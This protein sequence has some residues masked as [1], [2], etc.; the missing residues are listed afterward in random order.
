MIYDDKENISKLRMNR[1]MVDIESKKYVKKQ[2]KTTQIVFR[3]FIFSSVIWAVGT[4]H[5]F[6]TRTVL[7]TVEVPLINT[8]V[9]NTYTGF[10]IREETVYTSNFHNMNFLV[11]ENTRIRRNTAVAANLQQ[12]MIAETGGIVSFNLDG[13]E[14]L[15]ISDLE[16][17]MN[18]GNLSL[19]NNTDAIFRI[20][21]SNNWNIIS[22]IPIKYSESISSSNSISLFARDKFYP[23]LFKEIEA[24]VYKT[25]ILEDNLLVIFSVQDFMLDYINDRNIEFTLNNPYVTGLKVPSTAIANRT[26]LLIPENFIYTNDDRNYVVLTDEYGN[27]I[28]IDINP[29]RTLSIPE[30]TG[31]VYVNQDFRT[32]QIGSTIINNGDIYI[33]NRVVT[34]TGVFRVNS[35]ISIFVSI[36][37]NNSVVL[38]DYIILDRDKNGGGLTI[39]DRIVKDAQSNLV[40]S[41]QILNW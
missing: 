12:S 37:T 32:I 18:F 6:L 38:E 28:N 16:N 35:G 39:H 19:V 24:T 14:H 2:E 31:Y 40:Y 3:I 36:Y 25:E 8:V 33:V 34:D 7:E 21:T 13:F 10:I 11:E 9:T 20:I 41:G 23:Y 27:T 22:F 29:V 1:T 5:N 30:T 26:L 4:I 15:T 17:I